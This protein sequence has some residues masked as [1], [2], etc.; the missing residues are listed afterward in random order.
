MMDPN[1]ELK[2]ALY[3]FVGIGTLIGLVVMGLSYRD[4][5]RSL[6]CREKLRASLGDVIFTK[7]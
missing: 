1:L 5:M 6:K 2:I 7:E 3:V 4:Q